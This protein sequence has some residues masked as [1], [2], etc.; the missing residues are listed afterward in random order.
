MAKVIKT[1]DEPVI[2][3]RP[4]EFVVLF[5]L[6]DSC[7]E[8]HI[9]CAHELYEAAHQ[10]KTTLVAVCEYLRREIAEA[11][12]RERARKERLNPTYRNWRASI[13]P[14]PRKAKS[15]GNANEA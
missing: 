12:T 4:S 2:E 3:M 10:G 15:K 1:T 8:H 14:K 9:P 11:E 5:W 6:I 13:L 7:V